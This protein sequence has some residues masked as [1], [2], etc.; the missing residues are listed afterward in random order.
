MNTESYN[1]VFGVSVAPSGVA[2][3]VISPWVMTQGA[4]EDV[5]GWLLLLPP[6]ITMSKL[7]K[8]L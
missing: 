2:S 7:Q 8:L 1:Q 4:Q 6:R 3:T 5:V